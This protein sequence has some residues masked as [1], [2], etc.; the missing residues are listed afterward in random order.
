MAKGLKCA[1]RRFGLLSFLSLTSTMECPAILFK[2]L[3]YFLFFASANAQ[4]GLPPMRIF[5]WK[6]SNAGLGFELPSCIPLSITL[7]PFNPSNVTH[8][9][10][11]FYMLG[12]EVG[13]TP[14]LT[15]IGDNESSLSWTVDHPVGTQLMLNV[16]DAQGSSGGIPP[17]LY[18][19][20]NGQTTNCIQSGNDTSFTVTSNITM[21][22]ELNA[23]APWGLRIKGGVKPYNLTFAQLNS[24]NITNL[25]MVPPNADGYTYIQR[26][27]PD[28][29]LL[30]SV[31]DFTGRWAFGS[32]VI[33]PLGVSDC[34]GLV[35]SSGNA[36]E[37]DQA[38]K[39]AEDA[40]ARNKSNR[41]TA[42]IAGVLVPV[43]ALLI[44]GGIIAFY[45]RRRR[46]R[47]AKEI[48]MG[49]LDTIPKPFIDEGQILSINSFLDTH[50]NTSPRT[51]KT[52]PGPPGL[53]GHTVQNSV[54]SSEPFDPYNTT[55][56]SSTRPNSSSSSG[57]PGFNS[58]PSS[59]VRRPSANGKAAEAAMSRSARSDVSNPSTS[60]AGPS[61]PPNTTLIPSPDGDGEYIIQHRDGGGVVRELPPPYADR[62]LAQQDS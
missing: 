25:T 24:P 17:Q 10:P 33:N 58:F 45:I 39:E 44:G 43:L 2:F 8:G 14:R 48:N 38:Q 18:T 53:V 46:H 47:M 3:F 23:C 59:S 9:I 12:H 55:E 61:L 35:S 52:P 49:P 56:H 30:V 5:Q 36:T 26:G 31:S 28:H 54:A 51:P 16:V 60:Q 21:G 32:P 22:A 15:H 34:V 62:S 11:P 27:N 19:V 20:V 37:L 57:R 50:S 41:K 13:G 1:S 29:L 42:I 4:D 40:A 6:F 7:S